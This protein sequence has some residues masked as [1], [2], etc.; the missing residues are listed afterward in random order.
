MLVVVAPSSTLAS[1]TQ[2]SSL[3]LSQVPFCNRIYKVTQ[4]DGWISFGQSIPSTTLK[5]LYIRESYRTIASSINPGIN[6]AIITGNMHWQVALAHLP[7]M[8]VGQGRKMCPLHLL[9]V[10]HLL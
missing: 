1:Q 3:P 2:P 10:Q 4:R 6:K 5:N 7:L 8:E 9:S